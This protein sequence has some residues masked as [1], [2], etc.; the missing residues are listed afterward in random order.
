MT[1]NN[2]KYVSAVE[3]CR[4]KGISPGLFYRAVKIH[5]FPKHTVLCSRKMYKIKDVNVEGVLETRGI[6]YTIEITQQDNEIETYQFASY[7]ATEAV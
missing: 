6:N 5:G 2:S 1:D 3:F 7:E 4:L